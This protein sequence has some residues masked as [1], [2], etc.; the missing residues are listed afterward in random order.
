MNTNFTFDA[1]Y[2][3]RLRAK[4]EDTQHHFYDYFYIP[5]RN[6]VRHSLHGPDGD[7]LVQEVFAKAFERI[8]AGEPREAQ[9][10]PGYVFGICHNLLLQEYGRRKQQ[11]I[12][13][14]VDMS[15]FEDRRGSIEARLIRK[16]DQSR[17]DFIL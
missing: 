4:D 16:L 7:D 13:T 5:I 17:V 14:D 1:A 8:D 12:L 11:V 10:L 9:K 2:L 3:A 6:K 15:K